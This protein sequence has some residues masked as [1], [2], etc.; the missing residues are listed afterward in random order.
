M[1]DLNITPN[2]LRGQIKAVS[3]YDELERRLVAQFGPGGPALNAQGQPIKGKDGPKIERRVER[4]WIDLYLEDRTN[5][6]LITI[7]PNQEE[8][9]AK[10]QAQRKSDTI[11]IRCT[12]KF[13]YE[14]PSDPDGLLR[15]AL[16]HIRT[17]IYPKQ[18]LDDDGSYKLCTPDGT[19]LLISLEEMQSATY[20]M[21]EPGLPFGSVHVTLK[22]IYIE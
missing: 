10:A 17:A 16:K 2:A 13:D 6:P 5:W 4:G 11:H 22:L 15:L 19:K 20:V 14:H 3:I 9:N 12:I 21:P 8:V 18:E 7:E 1:F